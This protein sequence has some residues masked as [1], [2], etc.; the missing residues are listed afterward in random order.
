MRV[1]VCVCVCVGVCVCV[2]VEELLASKERGGQPAN[3]TAASQ[4]SV[5]HTE[6]AA[7][8]DQGQLLTQRSVNLAPSGGVALAG[9][10]HQPV[11]RWSDAG[12]IPHA[13]FA[14]TLNQGRLL[15]QN[16]ANVAPFGVA[17]TGRSDQPIDWSSDA[18]DIPYAGFGTYQPE[19]V[20]L[21]SRVKQAMFD[22]QIGQPRPEPPPT[23]AAFACIPLAKCPFNIPL[24]DKLL[25][26]YNYDE[27]DYV[28][29][30]L[31]HGVSFEYSGDPPANKP[32]RNLPVR[33][34][35]RAHVD[36]WVV[37]ERKHH[38]I[39][40]PFWNGKGDNP[41]SLPP[42]PTAAFIQPLGG[43]PKRASLLDVVPKGWR[44][45]THLSHPKETSHSVN[46]GIPDWSAVVTF[47][48]WHEI[49]DLL[50]TTQAEEAVS[51]DVDKAYRNLPLA[52]GFW[53][54]HAFQWRDVTDPDQSLPTHNRMTR[55]SG[56]DSEEWCLYYDIA[57]CFGLRAGPQVF[58]RVTTRPLAFLMQR[59]CGTVSA[60]TSRIDD[61]LFT[62]RPQATCA[63]ALTE[64]LGKYKLLG[65]D[66][67]W[68]Y[69]DPLRG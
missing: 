35:A 48:G 9:R 36:N 19:P 69:V 10:S 47:P 4:A 60:V 63:E 16:P 66:A 27:T 11:D 38:R 46:S 21:P 24:W 6:L 14:V 44:M 3:C 37:S 53:A 30:S 8:P 26:L 56:V 42:Q 62:V 64:V 50:V 61:S 45:I 68:V 17:L 43:V 33:A 57:L 52:K 59:L 13:E 67:A 15:I 32:V 22:A 58:T 12:D 39:I 65:Q 54:Y 25:R 1:C 18:G 5:P 40:G 41:R 20:R 7:T 55:G 23:P 34:A 28:V 51:V 49:F 2:C 31:T 29:D